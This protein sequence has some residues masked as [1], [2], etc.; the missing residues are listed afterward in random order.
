VTADAAA[1]YSHLS[2]QIR[3]VR[4]ARGMTQEAVDAAAGLG[5]GTV[6]TWELGRSRP[7]WSTLKRVADAM[8]VSILELIPPLDE[9]MKETV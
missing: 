7:R 9:W 4:V 8:D 1:F 6:Q 5:R 3:A 2:R